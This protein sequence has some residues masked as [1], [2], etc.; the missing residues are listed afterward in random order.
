MVKFVRVLYP[1]IPP[2]MKFSEL[3]DPS[4]P[5]ELLNYER[6]NMSKGAKFGLLFR[7]AGQTN[8]DD[9]FANNDVTNKSWQEFLPFLG[10]KIELTGFEGFRGGLDTK[11]RSTGTHSV[12]TK[13]GKTEIMFHVAPLLPW[14]PNDK[15]QL[16]RKRHIGNDLAVIIFQED[17]SEFNPT[18]LTSEMNHVFIVVT[19]AKDGY[20]YA[21]RNITFFFFF[22][23]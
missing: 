14:Y 19:A 16:E 5:N 17:E 10:D 4:M 8:E 6:K 3:H 22:S 9:M 13:H 12:Y 1:N 7:R 11:N 21:P 20:K 15:Q 2:Q 18:W 23:I